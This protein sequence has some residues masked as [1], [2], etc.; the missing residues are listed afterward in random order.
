MP[1]LRIEI[2]ATARDPEA[3][4]VVSVRINGRQVAQIGHAAP[5]AAEAMTSA[6]AGAIAAIAREE[7]RRG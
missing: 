3:N 4:A 1:D 7:V 5:T 2:H 6:L